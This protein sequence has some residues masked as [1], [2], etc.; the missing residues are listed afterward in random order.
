LR[1]ESKRGLGVTP[2][3]GRVNET[4]FCRA[5]KPLICGQGS[6]PCPI[7]ACPGGRRSGRGKQDQMPVRAV[8]SEVRSTGMPGW[9]LDVRMTSEVFTLAALGAGVSFDVRKRWKA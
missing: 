4:G 1:G 8:Q 3:G 6:L 5:E 7:T 2:P 9:R